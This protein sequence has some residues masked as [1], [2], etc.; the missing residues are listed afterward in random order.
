MRIISGESR[1]R[2]ISHD[3]SGDLR[4]TSARVR[5]A[6]FDIIQPYIEGA[7]FLDL[8]AGTGA[9]GIEAASR[10]ADNVTFV[11][12]SGRRADKLKKVADSF[13]MKDKVRIIKGEAVAFLRSHDESVYD[14]IFADPPYKYRYINELVEII[15]NKGIL[16][17]GGILIIE[18]DARKKLTDVTGDLIMEK[19]YRYGDSTITK[20]RRMDE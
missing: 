6:V 19:A 10:G 16:R 5:E 2:K 20:Y 13:G 1:G 11:E 14:I 4:P 12:I 7:R 9:V 17:R 18:H 8:F 3:R 15:Y